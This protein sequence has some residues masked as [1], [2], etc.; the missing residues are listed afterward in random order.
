MK[1]I[2]F[3]I[4]CIILIFPSIIANHS[5]NLRNLQ[6]HPSENQPDVLPEKHLNPGEMT[7]FTLPDELRNL[8][9]PTKCPESCNEFGK[10]RDQYE[11]NQEACCLDYIPCSDG[12]MCCRNDN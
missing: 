3:I 4:L 10:F 7:S 11:A 12:H 9:C 6:D 5:S 2:K 8:E 1:S